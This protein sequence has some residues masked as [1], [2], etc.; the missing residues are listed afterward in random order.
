MKNEHHEVFV[1]LVKC[2]WPMSKK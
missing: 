1:N 2:Y